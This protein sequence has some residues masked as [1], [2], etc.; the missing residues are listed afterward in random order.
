MKV[1]MTHDGPKPFLRPFIVTQV[2]GLSATLPVLK[3]LST[4]TTS[5]ASPMLGLGNIGAL[6]VLRPLST[7]TTFYASPLL[8]LGQIGA[9]PRQVV[10]AKPGADKDIPSKKVSLSDIATNVGI[11]S[12]ASAVPLGLIPLAKHTTEA[13]L[14]T[15]LKDY[16]VSPDASSSFAKSVLAFIRSNP[17]HLCCLFL[18]G[19][20]FG[21]GTVAALRPDLTWKRTLILG[22]GWFGIP[23]LIIG[24]ILMWLGVWGSSAAHKQGDAPAATSSESKPSIP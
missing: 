23:A 19:S 21:I 5:S 16:D 10:G 20:S 11:G 22:I 2:E 3:P 17:G 9:L 7:G 4:G 1:V 18:A 8:G 14:A 12:T 24:L 15:F 6:P 13:Q